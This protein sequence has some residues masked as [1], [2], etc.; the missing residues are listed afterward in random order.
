MTAAK[1]LSLKC[2]WEWMKNERGL[3]LFAFVLVFL[4]KWEPGGHIDATW[5]SAVARNIAEKGDFFHFYINPFFANEVFDH[6]P[7]DY[8][9]MGG[10][11][12]L[13][14]V[15]DF[16]ARLY[17]MIC[18]FASLLFLFGIARQIFGRTYGYITLIVFA[19]CFG[20][21]KWSGAIKH[22]VPL[23]MSYLACTYFFLKSFKQPLYL[24]AVAP[25]FALGVFSKGP[26]AFGFPLA[27]GIWSLIF[28]KFQW[29]RSKEFFGT[30]ILT[31]GFLA[32]PFLPALRFDGRDYYTVFYTAKK[33]Y[34]DTTVPTLADYLFYAQEMIVKQ[35]HVFLLF[36]FSLFILV[37]K[38]EFFEKGQRQKVWLFL[39]MV[40]S[41]LGPLSLFS[42]KLGYYTLPALPFYALFSSVGLYWWLGSRNWDW[43]KGMFRLGL[44]AVLMMVALPL[45][46]T[47]GRHKRVTNVVNQV[48]FLQGIHEMPVYFL[49]YYDE[50]MSIFQEFK[51]YGGIDLR[52][53][54]REQLKEISP[55]QAQ[56]VIRV[57]DL[58]AEVKG[59]E[60]STEKCWVLNSQYCVVGP[61]DQ[62]Q[63]QL[64][65]NLWPHEVY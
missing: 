43:S 22:D 32:L 65:D 21:T 4:K 40:V 12:S 64:P 58:P 8:W 47:G 16:I 10:L 52:P 1:N 57:Q 15:S 13:F 37:S 54:T 34:L 48:K 51:F 46:T 2:L 9:I 33:S 53:A 61:R 45:K 59:M 42:F 49:G 26:V 23:T 17:F 30:L 50:D 5:Y 56:F 60:V 11:M 25:F 6:F 39:V 20:A 41:I 7:L 63:I 44:V 55:E 62:L 3:L 24:L 29:M 27:V 36:L 28:L 31:V 38:K 19:L 18:S 14:G 35:P